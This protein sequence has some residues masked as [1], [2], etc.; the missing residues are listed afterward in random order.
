MMFLAIRAEDTH[1]TSTPNRVISTESAAIPI[2]NYNESVPIPTASAHPPVIA[3]VR[4]LPATG[5]LFF[6]FRRRIN[7]FVIVRVVLAHRDEK[8]NIAT[9][10]NRRVRLP[11]SAPSLTHPPIVVNGRQYAVLN[12]LGKGG[13]SKV[14]L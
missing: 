11:E 2:I 8:D 7:R 13:S 12:L 6:H 10:A 1:S 4:K 9:V 5:K 14:R 3:K